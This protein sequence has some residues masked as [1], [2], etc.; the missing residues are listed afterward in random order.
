MRNSIFFR[1]DTL[2]ALIRSNC[3]HAFSIKLGAMMALASHCTFRHG[4]ASMTLTFCYS[5][6]DKQSCMLSNRVPAK[7]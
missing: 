2:F 6:F 4:V 7:R 5:A 1:D 3:K